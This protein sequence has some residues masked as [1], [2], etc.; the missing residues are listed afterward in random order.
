MSLCL[1]RDPP[2]ECDDAR[3]EAARGRSTDGKCTGG[4]Y[5]SLAVK[6]WLEGRY[7]VVSEPGSA[8][9]GWPH[10]ARMLPAWTGCPCYRFRPCSGSVKAKEATSSEGKARVAGGFP[11]A[12][13]PKTS[14][15]S[16]FE[17]F[18][19]GPRG[20]VARAT[21]SCRTLLLFAVKGLPPKLK[22]VK[23]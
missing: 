19:I 11:H 13:R 2:K 22:R 10:C 15:V 14:L 12:K 4:A 18:R 8:C 1:Y 3:R 16:V 5:T 23:L 7:T 20:I 17:H 21:I 6:R 9:G